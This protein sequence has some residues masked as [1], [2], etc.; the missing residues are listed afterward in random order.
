MFLRS[1]SRLENLLLDETSSIGFDSVIIT[2]STN[3]SDP[4]DFGIKIARERASI[5]ISGNVKIDIKRKLFYSK[6]LNIKVAKSYGP[7]RYDKNYEIDGHDYPVGFVRW[8]EN[9]NMS[10]INNYLKRKFCL[11]LT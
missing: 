4:I 2:A 5:V 3:S 7:G 8:T 1:S 10:S 6:D 9:R 11:F